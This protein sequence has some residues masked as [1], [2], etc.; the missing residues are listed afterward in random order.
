MNF[1]PVLSEVARGFSP[2]LEAETR[3]LKHRATSE[4]SRKI[5]DSL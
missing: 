2:R 1:V 4:P 5:H 3:G